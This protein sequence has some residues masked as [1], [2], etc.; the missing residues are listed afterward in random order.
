MEPQSTNADAWGDFIDDLA[1]RVLWDRDFEDEDQW[2]DAP[3]P[4]E[5]G[6]EGEYIGGY[7]ADVPRDLRDPETLMSLERL[8]ALYDAR[9]RPGAE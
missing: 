3:P 5:V 7:F 6:A 4:S 2:A 9:L 8:A 1:D